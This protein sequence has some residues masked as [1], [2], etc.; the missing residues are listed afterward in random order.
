MDR[1]P[2]YELVAALSAGQTLRRAAVLLGQ[3]HA[4]VSRR[5]SRL[6]AQFV[7]PIFE[8]SAD[9]YART[10]LGD[11]LFLA[12][13]KMSEVSRVAVEACSRPRE[14][15]FAEIRCSFT[16]SH[17]RYLLDD[18]LDRFQTDNPNIRLTLAI[19]STLADLDRSEADVVLRCSTAPPEHLVGRALFPV[20]YSYYVS[21]DIPDTEVKTLS[22]IAHS[23]D[24]DPRTDGQ[25]SKALRELPV[26]MVSTSVLHRA[27]CVG[28]GKGLS[29]L[30]CFVGDAE[31]SLKR[32]AGVKIDRNRQLWVLTHPRLKTLSR[33]SAFTEHLYKGLQS[34]RSLCAGT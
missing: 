26:F 31:P 8:Q 20:G 21:K 9:G 10:A 34:K 15:A 7:E 6:N 19:V 22:W 16:D 5:L 23:T 30:P 32:L 14:G 12:S 33:I 1:W 18:V 4:T 17:V 25:L 28:A 13:Q 11:T 3:S 2:D 24:W 27:D 29:Y